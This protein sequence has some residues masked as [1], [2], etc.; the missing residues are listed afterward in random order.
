ME[1]NP[2]FPGREILIFQEFSKWNNTTH[3]FIQAYKNLHIGIFAGTLTIQ[4]SIVFF[5]VVNRLWQYSQWWRNKL[6]HK[7]FGSQTHEAQ[8]DITICPCATGHFTSL[9]REGVVVII[10]LGP[11]QN[12]DR[13]GVVVIIYH[14]YKLHWLDQRSQAVTSFTESTPTPVI[15]D[16]TS[17]LINFIYNV[18]LPTWSQVINY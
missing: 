13:E 2:Y 5:I 4:S 3:L 10:C 7:I 16:W 12:T 18:I 15:I 17:W 11:F 8:G 6:C 9:K 14:M 1:R